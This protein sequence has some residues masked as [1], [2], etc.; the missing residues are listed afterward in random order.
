M[1]TFDTPTPI[2]AVLDIPAGRI[3]LVAADRTDTTVEVLPADPAKARDTKAAEQI[4]VTYTD[5][6]LRIDAPEAGN[7]ILGHS[8]SIELTIQLP[9]GSRIDAKA[10]LAELRS[11]G[12]L[13]EV[14]FEGAQATV[15]LDEAAG[16]RLTTAA[17]DL[18]VARLTGSARITAQKGDLT[19]TEAVRGTLTL[20]T[21]AGR[22]TVGAARGTSAALDASTGFGRI[23]NALRNTGDTPD[24][25][26]VHATTAYG[27]ITA[28]SL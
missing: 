23:D 1:Q 12:R 11:T 2:T 16:A 3:H 21:D 10:D 9:A 6:V 4:R 20:R 14:G 18:A 17:G 24:H 5:G 22:I 15:E 13:G 27:D 8:G 19:V 26:T 25:L 28:R 7:R